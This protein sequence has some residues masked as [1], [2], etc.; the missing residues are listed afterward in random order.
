MCL[1]VHNSTTVGNYCL[2]PKGSVGLHSVLMELTSVLMELTC[3]LMELTS[4]LMELNRI[5]MELTCV[6]MDINCD[7]CT[8]FMWRYSAGLRLFIILMTIML[9]VGWDGPPWL[10]WWWRGGWGGCRESCVQHEDVPTVQP[11]LLCLL[12]ADTASTLPHQTYQ[13]TGSPLLAEE[14]CIVRLQC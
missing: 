9:I 8:A 14:G 7:R 12:S 3:V 13:R 10:H 4:V 6:L 5:L 11:G 1:L 2:E